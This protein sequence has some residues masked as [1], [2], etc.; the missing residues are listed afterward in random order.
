MSEADYLIRRES[1]LTGE[2]VAEFPPRIQNHNKQAVYDIA[3]PPGCTH[4]GRLE[5]SRWR[6]MP[7]PET[8]AGPF[9]GLQLERREDIFRYDPVADNGDTIE[10]YPNFAN[11]DLFCAYGRSLL[12]Q[13]ELQVAEHP[14]LGS[15]RE[16]LLASGRDH[17][18]VENGEPTPVLIAGAERRCFLATD[19]NAAEG[20]PDGLYGNQFGR[21]RADA[22]ARATHP[23]EPPTITNLVAMEAPVGG[24]GRYTQEQIRFILGTAFTAFTAAVMESKRMRPD[25]PEVAIHTGFWGCGAYGGHRILMTIL[26]LLAA[27]ACGPSRLVFY[28][29]NTLGARTLERAVDCIEKDLLASAAEVESAEIIRAIDALG[30]N[31]GVGNGT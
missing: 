19:P 11:A 14:A 13:D 25:T 3:C 23:M 21:A 31:W 17:L 27:R 30:F 8:I 1:F 15:L 18:T 22:V 26:Q 12:A 4:G 5:F 29:V 2:L 9:A 16:A 28:T 20:R 7:L 10:W 6:A 24:I